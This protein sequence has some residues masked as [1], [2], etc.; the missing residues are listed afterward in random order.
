MNAAG[1]AHSE[2]STRINHQPATNTDWLALA[3][4]LV[5][6]VLATCIFLPPWEVLRREPLF[7]KDYPVHT[8]RVHMYRQGLL[9]GGLPWGY[10]PAVSA[11]TVI[12]PTWDIG[13]ISQQVLGILLPFL[14][15]A[16]VVRLFLFLAVLTIPLWTLLACRRLKFPADVQVWVLVTLLALVWAYEAFIYTDRKDSPIGYFYWGLASFGAAGCFVPYVL[17]L[18]HDFLGRPGFKI[19]LGFCI[20]SACLFLLHIL[21]P[22]VLVPS[23]VLYTLTVRV[24]PRRWRVAMILA[25]LGILALNAFWF[26]PFLLGKGTP[27]PPWT[28][29]SA[30]IEDPHL[31]YVNSS[32]L[33]QAFSSPRAVVFYLGGLGLAIYGFVVLAKL[34]GRRTA[35]SFALAAAVALFLKY[36]GSFLPVFV[37]MQPVRFVIPAFVLLALP[38]GLALATLSQKVRLPARLFP[39]GL[40]LLLGVMVFLRGKPDNLPLPPNPDLLA[41]FVAHRTDPA[42]RL[43]IQSHDGYNIEGYE[44]KVFP[45]VYGREVIGNT[46]SQIFNPAQFLRHRLWGKNLETWTPSELQ[47]SLDRWGVAW[48]FTQTE[49]ARLL[50]VKTLG[51]VEQTVGKY[52][53]FRVAGSPTRFLVGKGKV[54]AKVNRLELSEL[55]PQDG[56]IVLRYLFHP[57]WRTT[58]GLPVHS[59][60]VPEHPSGFIAL[61]EPH[62]QETLQ[63]DSWAMLTASWPQ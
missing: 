12:H 19:F 61:N 33:V 24:L 3:F 39:V 51:N 41:N 4:V 56:R 7:F 23:L 58:S 28:P 22:V 16:A 50:F 44:A 21:G 8:H 59:Y 26:I 17:A 55:Q 49:E 46:F 62:E 9:E 52:H 30:L 45:L 48:V 47:L 37:K 34:A 38:I 29:I 32:H 20:A 25:P 43:L 35:V 10:D 54:K 18:F 63:F 42:E 14:P 15:P 40:A 5:L 1:Y 36:F 53:A 60:S 6:H 2:T 57:A 27:H 11:G 13:A 31:T